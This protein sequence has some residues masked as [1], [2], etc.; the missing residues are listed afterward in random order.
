MPGRRLLYLG[1]LLIIV[2]PTVHA[3]AWRKFRGSPV[4]VTSRL[5]DSAMLLHFVRRTIAR[6]TRSAIISIRTTSHLV[7]RA[8]LR[9]SRRTARVAI[10]GS[11]PV[12]QR[13]RSQ[14]HHGRNGNLA[15]HSSSPSSLVT[16]RQQEPCARV[17]IRQAG[18]ATE[19]VAVPGNH[20]RG[21]RVQPSSA[22]TGPALD[23]R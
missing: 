4:A 16:Q 3:I 11:L 21:D 22:S 9:S 20:E 17:P 12:S 10:H 14:K 1:G 8:Q 18:P 13:N 15:C 19:L 2:S 6:C 7:T 23:D 5:T